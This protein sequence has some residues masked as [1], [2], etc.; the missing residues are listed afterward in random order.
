MGQRADPSFLTSDHADL[1]KI[2]EAL[3]SLQTKLQYPLA[4]LQERDLHRQLTTLQDQTQ[5][6]TA[7]LARLRLDYMRWQ[8]LAKAIQSNNLSRLGLQYQALN[9]S[10]KAQAMEAVNIK[11]ML[12]LENQ[13][14]ICAA[15]QQ[16]V[17]HLDREALLLETDMENLSERIAF[18]PKV[19]GLTNKQSTMARFLTPIA[20]LAVVLAASAATAQN[21][22]ETQATLHRRN[23]FTRNKFA[24]GGAAAGGFTLGKTGALGGALIG[25]A[26]DKKYSH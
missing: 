3:A 18:S 12:E 1:P 21:P 23:I 9:L 2:R 17:A 10:T 14:S 26:A 15:K 6:A 7:Q 13:K 4:T 16:I 19:D 22:A 11:K 20:L 5:I 24:L 25:H 8:T